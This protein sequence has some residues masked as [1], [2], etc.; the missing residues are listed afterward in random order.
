MHKPN[1]DD[2][3]LFSLFSSAAASIPRLTRRSTGHQRAAHVDVQ[4]IRAIL[5]QPFFT[6]T[7]SSTRGTLRQIKHQVGNLS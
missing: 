2:H 7:C 5:A 3:R 4:L 6:S 1:I